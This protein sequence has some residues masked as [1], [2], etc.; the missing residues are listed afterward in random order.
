MS[1]GLAHGEEAGS[2]YGG[3]PTNIKPKQWAFF[4]SYVIIKAKIK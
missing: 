4:A 3:Q 1:D 2:N